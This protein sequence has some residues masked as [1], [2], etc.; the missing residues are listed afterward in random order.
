MYVGRQ[1]FILEDQKIKLV[2]H[3]KKYIATLKRNIKY[4]NFVFKN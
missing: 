1:I 3:F 4:G 2:T